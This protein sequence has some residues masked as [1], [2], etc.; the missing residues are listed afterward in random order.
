MNIEKKYFSYVF[1]GVLL[2]IFIPSM[3][4]YA[5]TFSEDHST[6]MQS[7]A[8]A[9]HWLSSNLNE[10][11]IVFLPSGYVFWSSDPSL[12]SKTE[13]YKTV[14]DSSHIILRANTT[15]SE[16]SKVRQELRNTIHNDKHVKYLVLDW[17][18]PYEV[19]LFK[20]NGCESFD[21]GLQEIKVF[22]FITPHDKWKNQITI[23][24][25]QNITKK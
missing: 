2:V 5:G 19:L 22:S 23:C 4:N 25:I 11:D 12:A 16:I 18:D 7:Y 9:T 15:E 13:S 17:V 3:W 14:W 6:I 10:D 1:V 20:K 8:F 21:D 24:K